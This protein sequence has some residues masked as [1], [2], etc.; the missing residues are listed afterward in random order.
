MPDY[1]IFGSCL[2]SEIPFLDLRPLVDAAPK[3][4]LRVVSKPDSDD[5]DIIGEMLNPPCA[6]RL[7]KNNAGFRLSHSCTAEYDVSGDGSRITCS[8]RPTADSESL[9]YDIANRVM[10]VALHASGALCLHGSAVRIAG[11]VIAFLA[12]KGYG[13]STLASALLS[14]GAQLVTDDMLAVKFLPQVSA[15]PGIFGLRLRDDSAEKFLDPS[16]QSRRGVD[17]KH[18]VDALSDSRVMLSE[19]PLSAIYM[20]A[21]IR[22]TETDA[23]VTRTLLPPRA[24]AM[25]LVTHAKIATLLGAAEA[26][27]VLERAAALAREVPVFQ[28]HVARDL[29]RLNEVVEL[30]LEWHSAEDYAVT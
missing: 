11:S 27:V 5:G 8:P 13:K 19:A 15:L 6:I 21:P 20:L 26:P 7:K 3:W 14:A 10:A 16:M 23:A 29:H 24:A 28:L 12:P 18:V 30:L 1:S 2:R 9:R 25:A 4:T 22:S 17:G